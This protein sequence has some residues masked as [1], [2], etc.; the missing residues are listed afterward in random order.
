[1][2]EVVLL[3]SQLG[4]SVFKNGAAILTDDFSVGIG[5]DP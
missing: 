3:Q 2:L 4:T 1:M 5:S